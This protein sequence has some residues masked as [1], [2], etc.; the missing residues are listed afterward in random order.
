MA[1]KMSGCIASSLGCGGP[2]Q[3]SLMHLS[4]P[5]SL[6]ALFWLL[7]LEELLEAYPVFTQGHL[8]A[9]HNCIGL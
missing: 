3:T 9:P 8:V 1:I 2:F 4:D 5:L 6:T 7:L